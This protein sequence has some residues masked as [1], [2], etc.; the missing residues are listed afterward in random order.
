M[1]KVQFRWMDKEDKSVIVTLEDATSD[2][3]K[4]MLTGSCNR[5]GLFN[6]AKALIGQAEH[7][8]DYAL[9]YFDFKDF[10]AI[11]H[12]LGMEGGDWVLKQFTKRLMRCGIG[13]SVKAK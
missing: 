13:I 1:A 2:A 6:K 11:N 9:L 12:L 8:S 4:D 3:E 7:P 10:K 5:M